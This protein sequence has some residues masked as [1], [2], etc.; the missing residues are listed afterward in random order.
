MIPKPIILN[1]L[2]KLHTFILTKKIIIRE[3]DTFLFIIQYNL[4]F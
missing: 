2:I 3:T 1:L 4:L